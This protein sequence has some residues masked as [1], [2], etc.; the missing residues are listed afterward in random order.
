[1]S[2]NTLRRYCSS[3]KYPQS[4]CV[5]SEI[6]IISVPVNVIILQHA[7]EQRH[8]K[9]TARLVSLCIPT[10]NIISTD[11]DDAVTNLRK[12]CTEANSAVI[13]PSDKSTAIESGSGT[14]LDGV[15]TVIFI[16][17]SWKQAF[18]MVQRYP[19]LNTL[20]AFHFRHA[21]N[22]SYAI[23]HTRVDKALSTLEAVAYT[24]SFAFK[25]DVT[26][27]HKA[28]RAM[29]QHWKGPQS[30]RRRSSE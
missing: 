18:G 23:R 27:L 2:K 12:H 14:P 4:T 7:K 29:Q 24:L 13:Y 5:C 11:D 1:M 26:S 30:H 8:A 16:D 28:Q 20:P 9:N 21:P 17:G 22:T 3:C 6:D 15:D 10:T 19:W 25:T